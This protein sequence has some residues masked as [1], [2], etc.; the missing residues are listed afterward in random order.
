M[1][2]FIK[3]FKNFHKNVKLPL[4]INQLINGEL[5]KNLKFEYFKEKN[6]EIMGHKSICYSYN[7][8]FILL[9]NIDKC[10]AIL[11]IDDKSS[12]LKKT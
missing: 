9:D 4:I 11:F 8:L 7:D 10:K 1:P 5:E 2:K 3:Y 12:L 6:N